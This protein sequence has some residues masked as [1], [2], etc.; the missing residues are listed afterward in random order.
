MST[1]FALA[2]HGGARTIAPGSAADEASYRDAL[3]SALTTG[4]AVLACG[5]SALD[6]VIATVVWS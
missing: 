1:P 6:A 5:G 2:L 3:R 4:Q